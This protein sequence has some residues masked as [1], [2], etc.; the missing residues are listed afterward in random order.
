MKKLITLLFLMPAILAFSQETY[1][2]GEKY[3]KKDKAIKEARKEAKRWAKDGYQNTP[4]NLS[5]S[6]QFERAM[7]KRV[8]V[9]ENNVLRFVSASASAISGSESV[10]QANAMDNARAILAG[11]IQTEVSGLISNN[12][13]NTAYSVTEVE[14][15]DEFISN[16]K[17]LIQNELGIIR[18]EIEMVRRVGDNFE[19][20]YT[21]LYDLKE[22]K[23]VTKNL[24]KRDLSEK[25][26]KN[27]E[28]LNKILGLD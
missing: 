23:L 10:A 17:T 3:V 19:F 6:Q 28:E 2:E 22:A 9:D 11:Q 1:K 18:P 7:V 25:L 24:M 12:K 15:I 8:M 5:L 13:A 14:T 27:E 26:G 16:S 20:R 21:L 4:G